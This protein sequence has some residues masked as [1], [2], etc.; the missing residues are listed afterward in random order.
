MDRGCDRTPSM[1]SICV[2]TVPFTLGDGASGVAM[3]MS[4][5]FYAVGSANI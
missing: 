2:L 5:A 1:F 4:T 3:V